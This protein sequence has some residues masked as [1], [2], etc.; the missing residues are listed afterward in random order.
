MRKRII[1]GKQ[2][3]KISFR[4]E[5]LIIL[6]ILVFYSI[7]SPGVEG[8]LSD[9][10]CYSPTY[11]FFCPS[12]YPSPFSYS[13]TE[14]IKSTI[15]PSEFIISDETKL[16]LA[17]T[18]APILWLYKDASQEEPFTLIEADYFIDVSYI[19]HSGNYKLLKDGYSGSEQLQH[20][21]D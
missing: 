9:S 1:A 20:A 10:S 14:E 19:D 5:L 18:Y 4:R 11:S 21:Y 7:S 3:I 8:F 15:S 13:I 12:S 6:A 17:Q 16:Q 2:E